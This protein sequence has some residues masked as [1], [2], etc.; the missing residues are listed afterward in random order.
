MLQL[1]PPLIFVQAV[2]K[3]GMYCG[4][5]FVVCVENAA[6]TMHFVGT[7][8]RKKNTTLL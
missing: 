3:L 7:N 1:F 2:G 8:Y 6:Q 5:L 4:L